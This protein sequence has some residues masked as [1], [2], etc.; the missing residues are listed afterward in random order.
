MKQFLLS[1]HIVISVLLLSACGGGSK[2]SSLS[3]G[4]DT[5]RLKYA[6]NLCLTTYPDYTVATLQ[7]PWHKPNILHTYILVDKEK[8]T[9]THL[10]EGTVV[11]VPLERSMVYSSVHCNLFKQLESLDAVAGVCGLQ[12]I[13]VPEI[14]EG[15]RNGSVTDCGNSMNPDIEKIIDIHPDAILLSPF[16]NSGGYGR[17]EKLNVPIIEC[18]DYMETSPLGRAEWMYFYGLLTGRKAQADSLFRKVEQSYLDIK[19]KAAATQTR[20]TVLSDLKYGSVWY[21]A[22]GKVRPVNS[23]RMPEHATSSPPCPT[24]VPFP[25]PSKP[26]STRDKM[27]TTGSSSTTRPPTRLTVNWLQT[28]RRMPTSPHT[29]T[30]VSTDATPTASPITKNCLSGR[31]CC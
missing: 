17:I 12:Y 28:T 21:I 23:M 13:K 30:N 24:A 29:G 20:P 4:G 8:P 1:A 14:Q 27:P 7:D 3:D 18:A 19:R 11:K 25:C 31:T 22:G 6:E 9:P 16:E 15:C 10:P 26:Y 2:T 5:L